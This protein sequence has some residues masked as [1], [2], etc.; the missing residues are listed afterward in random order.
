MAC[1][2]PLLRPWART[3]IQRS[4]NE[5]VSVYVQ[6]KGQ[7]QCL[8]KVG[9]ILSWAGNESHFSLDTGL[10]YDRS[11]GLLR[12]FSCPTTLMIGMDAVNHWSSWERNYKFQDFFLLFLLFLKFCSCQINANG[13]RERMGQVYWWIPTWSWA[14]I[15]DPNFT[16]FPILPKCKD[17]YPI[18]F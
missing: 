3:W 18:P 9:L 7:T 8:P 11:S 5:L 4:I 13:H 1:L 10:G 2:G 17:P 6:W 14:L 16:K 15:M 12:A